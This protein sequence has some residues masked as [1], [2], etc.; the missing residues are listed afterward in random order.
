MSST[1]CPR[2]NSKNFSTR[3]YSPGKETGTRVDVTGAKPASNVLAVLV[4][5]VFAIPA[6]L[7]GIWFFFQ[8]AWYYGL[9]TLGIAYPFAKF[10]AD[11]IRANHLLKER[12]IEHTCNYCKT[13]WQDDGVIL[14]SREPEIASP[15]PA[16][17]EASPNVQAA[18]VSPLSEKTENVDETKLCP[19]CHMESNTLFICKECGYI[20]R[21]MVIVLSVVMIFGL[22]IGIRGLLAWI[23]GKN[24]LWVEIA[25]TLICG[26][27]GI[28][29][30]YWGITEMIHM[31]R[32]RGW[33]NRHNQELNQLIT[34]YATNPGGSVDEAGR[35]VNH[36]GQW[37]EITLGE[38]ETDK[39]ITRQ[40]G[41]I[42]IAR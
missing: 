42:E 32:S 9:L 11:T 23:A 10:S 25:K 8:D 28:I 21:V 22:A 19:R 13:I 40:S 37:V 36:T 34:F 30:G 6:F 12:T 41:Q 14:E 1:T 29:I 38:L 31:T 2:C 24:T 7:G 16:P 20:N 39:K 27:P 4:I 5:I 3:T 15:S 18:Q 17:S 33:A 26:L 35:F